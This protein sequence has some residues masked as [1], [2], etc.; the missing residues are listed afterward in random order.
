VKA[1]FIQPMLLLP[2]DRLPDNRA[3]YEYGLKLDGYR[4]IGFKTSGRVFLRSRN[5][6][7]FTNRYPTVVKGLAGLAADTVIDGE[8]V[9]LGEAGKPSFTLLA[10][11]GSRRPIFYYVFDVMV[12]GGRDIMREPFAV[13]RDPSPVASGRA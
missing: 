7:D 6:K 12:L 11:S 13:R 9:A 2:T 3:Q 8:I 1:T 4:A 10:N 5:D